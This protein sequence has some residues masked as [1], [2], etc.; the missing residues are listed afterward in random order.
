MHPIWGNNNLDRSVSTIQEASE[1][2]SSFNAER[3]PDESRCHECILEGCLGSGLTNLLWRWLIVKSKNLSYKNILFR[4]KFIKAKKNWFTFLWKK[5]KKISHV[6]NWC[7]SP[8]HRGLHSLW[9]FARS[10]KLHPDSTIETY[11]TLL[12]TWI[13]SLRYA[14]NVLRLLSDS[15]QIKHIWG[16]TRH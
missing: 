6:T 10:A 2:Q 11:Q 1:A 13:G 15:P 12:A 5:E 16:I 4:I 8:T 7:L 3:C 14:R 9:C